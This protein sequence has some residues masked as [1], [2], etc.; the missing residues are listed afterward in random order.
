MD[1]ID[2][3]QHLYA[4]PNSL[5]KLVN[6]SQRNGIKRVCLSAC[7][8][9]YQQPGNDAVRDA[10]TKYPD[11]IIG[12]GYIR[13][14]IDPPSRI[15]YLHE[16]GFKG[17]KI[18]NPRKP[19]NAHEFFPS[20]EKAAKYRMP[21]LFHTGIAARIETVQKFQTAPA[22]F[23]PIEL[24]RIARAFPEL[25]LIGAHLGAPWFEEAC[26]VAASNPNVYFD[27]SWVI[28]IL[29]EKPKSFFDQLVYW[30]KAKEKLLLRQLRNSTF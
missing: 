7:G 13:L 2:A 10:F 1:I 29:A 17:I 26:S 8:E 18:I 25:S 11:L 16:E 4:E 27:L 9:Q 15:D 28:S 22:S 30:E 14:G 5:E 21:V 24:A 23:R 12:F 20:Y 19:Y 3:H 6:I